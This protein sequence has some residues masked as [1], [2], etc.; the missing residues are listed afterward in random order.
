[1]NIVQG[2]KLIEVD[3]D[4]LAELRGPFDGV[5]VDLGAGDG[6]FAYRYA[7]DHAERFVI[8][9]DPVAENMREMS[10][11]ASAKPAKGG[12]PNLVF[13]V[14][15]VEQLPDELRGLADEVH[16]LLPWGSLMRGLILAD[17]AVLAGVAA[18]AGRDGARLT[19]VL[20]TRIF[21]DPM[22]IE[23]RD[24]PPVT[25]ELVRE[26]L[27]PVYARH[28]IVVTESREL[29]PSEVAELGTTWAKRLSHR[30]PPPSV[31]IEGRIE[32]VSDTQHS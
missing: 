9:V 6:R 18:L 25:P 29:R 15:S 7:A 19:I 5:T 21:D 28:G 11:K 12:L 27:A 26:M 1:M 32:P 24:L 16:V 2:K 20:N 30:R 22:P 3:A 10:T 8:G 17:D 4:A 31:L 23:A 14:A 13:A